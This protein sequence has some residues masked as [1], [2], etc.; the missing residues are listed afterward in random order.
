MG[1]PCQLTMQL[2]SGCLCIIDD[3]LLTCGEYIL[4]TARAGSPRPPGMSKWLQWPAQYARRLR[5]TRLDAT[6]G[7]SGK[8]PAA[9]LLEFAGLP[10]KP[11]PL[12]AAL[13][14]G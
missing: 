8:V 2:V 6:G 11:P 13:R 12:V 1:Q 10:L 4:A 14:G 5:G 3:I 7:A 9:G